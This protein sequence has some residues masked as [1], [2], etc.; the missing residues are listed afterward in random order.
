[1]K[2]IYCAVFFFMEIQM[3]VVWLHFKHFCSYIVA[4]SFRWWKQQVNF[5]WDDDEVHFILD[6]HVY[7]DIYSASSQKQQF[8]GRHVAPL[9]HINLIPSQPVFVLSP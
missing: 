2:L 3:Y 6:Q 4:V 1:M 9:R 7:L 5:Q 8:T